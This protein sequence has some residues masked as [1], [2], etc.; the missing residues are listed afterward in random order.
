M[1]LC[2]ALE[3]HAAE[4]YYPAHMPGHKGNP[5]Y[6][7]LGDI[8]KYDITEIDG[9]D[10]LHDAGGVI[11]ESEK[12]AAK[13]YGV[14]ETRF[15]ING[16]TVGV[17]C[18]ISAVTN[19]GD[20]ILIGRNCHR[21]VYNAAE[22]NRLEV[23]YIYPELMKDTGIFLGISAKAVEAALMA[24]PLIRTVVIT[25]PT[26]EG[27]SSDIAEIARVSH[28][29]GALL[30]VD[31]AHGAHFGF[32]EGFPA[33]AARQGADIIINSVHKTLPA[34]T[35]TAL[36]HIND[37]N[38]IPVD[39]EA[40]RRYLG[41]YQSTSPSYLL[42]AGIDN[43]M[44]IISEHGQELF[45]RYLENIKWFEDRAL[46]LK[47]LRVI[48]RKQLEER[49]GIEDADPCKLMICPGFLNDAEKTKE[50]GRA[51]AGASGGV[52]L[53]EVCEKAVNG[54]NGRELYDILREDFRIQPEMAADR[55]CLLIMTVMDTREGFERLINAL[56][57]IDE[58]LD[59]KK[60][61][62]CSG[63]NGILYSSRPVRRMNAYESGCKPSEYVSLNKAA[64]RVA[65]SYVFLYPPGI[66]ILVP[67]EEISGEM[68]EALERA[69]D[70]GLNVRGITDDKEIRVHG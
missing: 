40:I 22:L 6:S 20:R 61:A 57:S 49:C 9:L 39:R 13:L 7:F 31:A 28:K 50:S 19:P 33:S 32:H 60:T 37:V 3:R 1:R 15:L 16:S 36:L 62:F 52:E 53:P 25:S 14:R 35:Q 27:I 18:A 67:G 65:S 30:I 68:A 54:L 48:G 46:K 38:G 47:H 26:Y 21:S 8:L 4:G 63:I 34:P 70:R 10:D 24:D 42:M 11:L 17:L 56:E 66:P 12:Y 2:E 69:V 58:K 51:V 5:C 41:I 44:S 29:Y 55:Y 59:K 43:C 45:D 64:G 23:H